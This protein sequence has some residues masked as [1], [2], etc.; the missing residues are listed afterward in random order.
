MNIIHPMLFF[1][2]ESNL[3]GQSLLTTGLEEDWLCCAQGAE[4]VAEAV[5]GQPEND[6]RHKN[7]QQRYDTSATGSGLCARK[8]NKQKG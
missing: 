6:E 5:Q 1:D 8:L 4:F 3:E 2:T 7:S